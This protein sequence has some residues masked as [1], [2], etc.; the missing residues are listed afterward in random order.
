MSL[1]AELGGPL[2]SLAR[3]LRDMIYGFYVTTEG[4]YSLN[5]QSGKLV[6]V[7]GHRIDLALAY[8]CKTVAT[9]MRNLP[10]QINAIHITTNGDQK[11]RSAAGRY[12][13]LFKR[14][15]TLQTSLLLA[16][17]P[18]IDKQILNAVEEAH[19]HML[20]IMH[21]IQ[22]GSKRPHRDRDS[23]WG[24]VPS[25]YRQ[26]VSDI[27]QLFSKRQD[28][29]NVISSHM[30]LYWLAP[31]LDE[32]INL[33]QTPW[34][35]PS[36][37]YLD[38]MC[39][40]LGTKTE[41][42]EYY[43][44]V[45]YRLSA[46]TVAISFL[47]S[48]SIPRRRQ[49]RKIVLHEDRVSTSWPE[50]HVRGLI[51]WCLENPRLHIERRVNLWRNVW[52]ASADEP[53]LVARA[54]PAAREM[55]RMDVLC[56]QE[57]SRPCLAP[58]IME[59]LSLPSLGMPSQAF[60]L[61][62]DGSPNL[63]AT[64]RVFKIAQRDAAWQAAFFEAFAPPSVNENSPLWGRMIENYSYI[65][66]GFPEAI[67]DITE[68]TSSIISCNFEPDFSGNDDQLR[69]IR[70][71]R[72]LKKW[73]KKWFAH[74]PQVFSTEPPLPHWADLRREEVLPKESEDSDMED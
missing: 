13:A 61:V 59:A 58:W 24:E 42:L 10:L 21:A 68:N 51:P 35:H 4:G 71:S 44:N 26:S 29:R 67:R 69:D 14:Q 49:L 11:F 32:I 23:S 43:E 12:N 2:F 3:E 20:P 18:C 36:E 73:N 52:P 70:P 15:C 46:A 41:E 7:E 55:D 22:R 40:I 65:M 60:T 37:T 6:T 9:E 19:P 39:R 64:A 5:H 1:T 27:L 53:S 47:E 63:S 38:D 72:N 31:F 74:E 45:L 8:T 48:L 25:V 28:F 54:W 33:S 34:V 56:S 50:C 30:L 17:R 62:L 57:I 66:R 16:A